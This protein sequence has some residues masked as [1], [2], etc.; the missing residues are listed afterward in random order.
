MV[1]QFFGAAW[2]PPAKHAEEYLAILSPLLRGDSVDFQGQHY[3]ASA[4]LSVEGPAPRLLLAALGPKM[5][6]LAG[7]HTD[8]TTTWMTGPKTLRT[9][10]VPRLQEAAAS[11]G[12]PSPVVVAGFPVCLS[13]DPSAVRS[14]AA[15]Q[16]SFY[17]QLPSYR[18]MLEMEGVSEPSEI[19]ITGGEDRFVESL[20][21]LAES[22]VTEVRLGIVGRD[23]A[24][25]D[26]TASFLGS[27][28]R[29]EVSGL[30]FWANP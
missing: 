4:K 27:I 19:I 26:R 17:A 7:K 2:D 18:R 22:G 28:G 15:K 12:R 10:I 3:S 14:F 16:L 20:C 25:V 23:E 6:A 11:A 8:G 21:E 24:E 1:Q 5:L 13:E 29:G 9:H 30:E